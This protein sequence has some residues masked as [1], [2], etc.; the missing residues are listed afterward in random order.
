M[1]FLSIPYIGTERIVF[2]NCSQ[3]NLKIFRKHSRRLHLYFADFYLPAKM[4]M[5]CLLLFL[6]QQHLNKKKKELPSVTALDFSLS[7]NIAHSCSFPKKIYWKHVIS[8]L[9]AYVQLRFR[10]VAAKSVQS[11][12]ALRQPRFCGSPWMR[13]GWP[14][15]CPHTCL[16]PDFPEDLLLSYAMITAA[17]RISLR[18]AL[19]P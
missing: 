11:L 8:M 19:R 16:Y 7:F 5:F 9:P 6:Q 12:T 13:S 10:Q 3:K 4:M 1:L 14:D 15:L 18:G 2:L 17:L